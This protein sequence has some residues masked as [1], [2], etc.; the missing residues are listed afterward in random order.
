MINFLAPAWLLGLLITPLFF[1]KQRQ[2][3]AQHLVAPHL[4]RHT[5]AT[6]PKRHGIVLCLAWSLIMVALAGPHWRTQDVPLSQANRARVVVMEVNERMQRDDLLPNRFQQAFYKT[7]DYL[8]RL[9]E[10][11]TAL[12]A[13]SAE[14]YTISPLTHDTQTV[15]TQM[16]HL[17]PEIM[18]RQG[19]NA[20]KGIEEALTLLA[21]AEFAQT[22]ILL[23]AS[24]IDNDESQAIAALLDGSTHRLSVLMINADR[25]GDPLSLPDSLPIATVAQSTHGLA[26]N[27]Q[28]DFSDIQALI[29]LDSSAIT[30]SLNPAQNTAQPI[31]DG[32]WLVWPLAFGLLF[33]FRR[34]AV[35]GIALLFV[36]PPSE[37]SSLTDWFK[38]RDKLAHQHFQDRVYSDAAELFE[39]PHWQGA[40]YYELGDYQNAIAAFSNVADGSADY[41]LANAYAKAGQLTQAAELYH[42][43]IA[44]EPQ[45]QWA[46]NNLAL[47]EDLLAQQH[48]P[49]PS[50]SEETQDDANQDSDNEEG[51]EE[52][53]ETGT[54][55]TR[56]Q[57]ESGDGDD[58]ESEDPQQDP[59]S[60]DHGSDGN[61]TGSSEAGSDD[62]GQGEQ[63]GDGERQLRTG[64]YDADQFGESAFDEEIGTPSDEELEAIRQQLAEIADITEGDPVLNRL[65]QVESDPS[66]LL[67]NLLIQQDQ[68]KRI[69]QAPS[70]N[71]E[72][73]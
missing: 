42:A 51:K 18:P 12:V 20:A 63:G 70:S 60:A 62:F 69:E 28:P 25:L 13:Y 33:A 48:T 50:D 17:S 73:P 38:N 24:D 71:K 6:R 21:S 10:G 11:Y 2:A 4:Q 7:V 31:N 8:H 61:P 19:H 27:S 49:P 40:A 36:L 55:D 53:D 64:D 26:L 37:A 3:Q 65:T 72:T 30:A 14:G 46:R 29:D 32:Y 41:N 44:R 39:D 45:H 66:Q 57:D 16:A 54:P 15:L 58:I 34:G 47:V 56:Q 23:I 35:W 68:Q 59:G 22:D 9:D 67:R 5:Q 1:W 52:G 43:V